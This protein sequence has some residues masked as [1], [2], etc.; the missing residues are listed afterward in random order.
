MQCVVKWRKE[1]RVDVMWNECHLKWKIETY[2]FIER[3]CEASYTYFLLSHTHQM[4]IILSYM[5]L[6]WTFYKVF[7]R[8]L[9]IWMSTVDLCFMCAMR[10]KWIYFLNANFENNRFIFELFYFKLS[11][12]NFKR[13]KKYILKLV[14]WTFISTLNCLII[15]IQFHFKK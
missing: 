3:V 7:R 2:L 12:L 10:W 8:N 5:N 4:L 14:H 9:C 11:I 1:I 15:S 6:K 13:W